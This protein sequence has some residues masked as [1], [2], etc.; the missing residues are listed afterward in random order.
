VPNYGVKERIPVMGETSRWLYS[1]L[2]FTVGHSSLR[3]NVPSSR[4]HLEMFLQLA[5]GE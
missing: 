2:V 1:L 5:V 4:K 3:R